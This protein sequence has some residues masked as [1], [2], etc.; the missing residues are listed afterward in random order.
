MELNI[1]E[2]KLIL[3]T[4]QFGKPYGIT[5]LKSRI[6]QNQINKILS[7][8]SKRILEIDTSE[9]YDLSS[10]TK[11]QIS[12]YLIN[13]KIHA[14]FFL[15][16]FDDLRIYFKKVNKLYKINILFV[17]DIENQFK[18]KKIIRNLRKLRK[19][20]LFQKIGISVY[21]Y[22]TIKLLYKILKYEVIQLP[23]IYLITSDYYAN[24][25]KK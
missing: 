18:N 7:F 17:R 4:A 1:F 9:D 5:N 16:S 20:N 22:K 12:D 6:S 25:L 14:H 24:F 11:E 15:N 23:V 8:S 21:D 3:G 13:T 10:K 19:L 2:K